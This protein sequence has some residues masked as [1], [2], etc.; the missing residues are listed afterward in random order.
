MIE[1]GPLVDGVSGLAAPTVDGL[2]FERY[3]EILKKLAAL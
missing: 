2:P 3:S 1:A